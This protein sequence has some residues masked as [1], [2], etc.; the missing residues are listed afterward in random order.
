LDPNPV[1]AFNKSGYLKTIADNRVGGQQ[2]GWG[3]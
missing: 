2:A 3:A 1:E